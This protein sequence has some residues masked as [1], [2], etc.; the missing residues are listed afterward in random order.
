MSLRRLVFNLFLIAAACMPF[1]VNAHPHGWIDLRS[2]VILDEEGRIVAIEQ[3]WLFDEWY[4][5]YATDGWDMDAESGQTA[6]TELAKANLKNLREYDY[7][8]EVEI[9]GEKQAIADVVD[10]ETAMKGSRIWMRIVTPLET[11]LDA[12]TDPVLYRVFDP[13]YYI[14]VLYLQGDV[15][16]FEGNDANQCAG[17]IIEPA[18]T[19]EA[20]ALAHSAALDYEANASVGQYFAQTV[21]VQCN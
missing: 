20:M 16:A 21:T 15:I 4:S 17:E 7:F 3:E 9:D 18:P 14:E 19:V 10:Y 6:L 2:K 13:T 5:V 8:T 11:P 1:Q 12:A